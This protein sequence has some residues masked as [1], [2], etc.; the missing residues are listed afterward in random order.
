VNR[1]YDAGLWTLGMNRSAVNR[2][3]TAE[4]YWEIKGKE[5]EKD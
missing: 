4:E 2:L 5:Y 1:Y 3:I